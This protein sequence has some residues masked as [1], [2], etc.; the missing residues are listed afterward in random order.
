MRSRS[1]SRHSL[2]LQPKAQSLY[3]NVLWN[4]SGLA[5]VVHQPVPAGLTEQVS[6]WGWPNEEASWSWAGSEGVKL[7]VNVYTQ[8]THVQ[9]LLNGAVVGDAQ[10]GDRFTATFSIPYTP[11]NLTARASTPA[12]GGVRRLSTPEEVRTLLTAGAPAAVRL[13]ADR[14]TICADRSDLAYV[15]AEVVDARGEIVPGASVPIEFAVSGAGLASHARA[16]SGRAV[17]SVCLV[18]R[19]EE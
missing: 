16:T 13:T 1:P 11:G 6:A 14:S 8:H 9:L 4:V 3:R 10:T 12:A 18:C 2:T 7:Q 17:S 19:S 15:A 5:L